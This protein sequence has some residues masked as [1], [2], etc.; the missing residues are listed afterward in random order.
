MP[1]ID[2]DVEKSQSID[3]DVPCHYLAIKHTRKIFFFFFKTT[4]FPQI[5]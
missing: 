4:E 1:G 3:V 2:T 5:L